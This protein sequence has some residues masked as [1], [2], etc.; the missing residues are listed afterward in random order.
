M[1]LAA[2]DGHQV[3]RETLG[4]AIYSSVAVSGDG[5]RAVVGVGW[6]VLAVRTGDGRVM[7]RKRLDGLVSGSPSLVGDRVYVTTRGGSLWALSTGGASAGRPGAGSG[8]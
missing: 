8:K 1:A 5:S 2:S 7:W 3:W 4:G 6:D